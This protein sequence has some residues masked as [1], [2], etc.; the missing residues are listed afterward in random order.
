MRP[1]RQGPSARRAQRE[2]PLGVG[3]DRLPHRRRP[4]ARHSRRADERR[5][6]RRHRT[7][8]ARTPRETLRQVRL[9]PGVVFEIQR[10]GLPPASMV[11]A[12]M[13]NQSDGFVSR[14]EIARAFPKAV[15]D[16]EVLT[17]A[18][19][20]VAFDLVLHEL[21]RHGLFDECGLVFKGGTAIRKF[22][23]R[24]QGP[25]LVRSRLRH[26]RGPRNCRRDGRRG[27]RRRPV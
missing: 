9:P 27:P 1:H 7:L 2:A 6:G 14:N 8:R 5:A 17:A 24:A 23:R 10:H 26:H 22:P 12:E 18:V 20:D 25:V 15:N 19:L 3:E 13:V 11:G 4:A 16:S 21:H